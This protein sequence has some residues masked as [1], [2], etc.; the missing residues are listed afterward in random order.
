[1]KNN[2][3]FD[4]WIKMPKYLS[5]EKHSECQWEKLL[6]TDV[7]GPVIA[8]CQL[9]P[10]NTPA[11][12]HPLGDVS[13]KRV[14]YCVLHQAALL[15]PHWGDCILVLPSQQQLPCPHPSYTQVLAVHLGFKALS[16]KPIAVSVHCLITK[17]LLLSVYVR[18]DVTVQNIN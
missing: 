7:S 15:A 5:I 11:E 3:S 10:I 1:M 6:T 8:P 9:L 16:I 17:C 18:S 13:I 14:I 4:E 12:M 2:P